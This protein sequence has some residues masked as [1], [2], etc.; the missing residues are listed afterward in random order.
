MN[1]I[2]SWTIFIVVASAVYVSI[3]GP[4]AFLKPTLGGSSKSKGEVSNS[5]KKRKRKPTTTAAA[6]KKAGEGENGMSFAEAVKEGEKAKEAVLE[7]LPV[8]GKTFAKAVKEEPEPSFAEVVKA[9]PAVGKKG[10]KGKGKGAAAAT[11]KEVSVKATAP[12]SP[13][14]TL[15]TSTPS[16]PDEDDEEEEEEEDEFEFTFPTSTAQPASGFT[17]NGRTNG[18]GLASRNPYAALGA[19]RQEGASATH[20]AAQ[21]ADKKARKA[22]SGIEDMLPTGTGVARSLKI[23]S[24][25]PSPSSSSQ[26]QLKQRAKKE[27]DDDEQTKK[28]RQNAAKRARAKAAK[29]REE[30]ERLERLRAHQR[31]VEAERVKEWE[32]SGGM[33]RA[34]ENDWNVV[35]KKV[36]KSGEVE[37]KEEEA[38]APALIWE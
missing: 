9:A 37:K 14:A 10:K 20:L 28:Q 11:G 16:I 35:G 8:K 26:Q 30:E 31:R 13:P 18:S 38:A 29:Q 36:Q 5:N 25:S 7:K 27:E 2:I 22:Y 23:T 32:K 34:R 12:P 1:P 21:H 17:A 24:S 15:S 6:A 4:P 33:Q 3:N 19:Q